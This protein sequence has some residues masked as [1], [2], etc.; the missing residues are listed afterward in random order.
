M[1]PTMSLAAPAANGTTAVI[2]RSG[3]PS[4]SAAGAAAQTSRAPASAA[5]QERAVVIDVLPG[6]ALWRAR[7]G[8][9]ASP[10]RTMTQ[11]ARSYKRGRTDYDVAV[12]SYCARLDIPPGHVLGVMA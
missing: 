2:V 7:T 1:R 3:H 9:R 5:Q 6:V 12:P 8:K 11:P 10:A 4:A